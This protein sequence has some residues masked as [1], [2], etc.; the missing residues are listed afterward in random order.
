[1]RGLAKSTAPN[2]CSTSP[3]ISSTDNSSNST[4]STECDIDYKIQDPSRNTLCSIER[5]GSFS[6]SNLNNEINST[7]PSLDLL[8]SVDTPK[9]MLVDCRANNESQ[10][11]FENISPENSVSLSSNDL[12]NCINPKECNLNSSVSNEVVKPKSPLLESDGIDSYIVEKSLKN[13]DNV[14]ISL[15]LP[16]CLS[17]NLNDVCTQNS[18]LDKLPAFQIPC[19]GSK[20]TSDVR[21]SWTIRQSMAL[22]VIDNIETIIEENLL[23]KSEKQNHEINLGNESVDTEISDVSIE[24]GYQPICPNSSFDDS[25]RSCQLMEVE[26]KNINNVNEEVTVQANLGFVNKSLNNVEQNVQKK[27]KKKKVLDLEECSW[28]DLYDKDDD[29]IHPILMKEVSLNILDFIGYL[30]TM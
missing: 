21:K 15:D 17:D 13:C 8:L 26:E 5:K 3:N 30:K 6:Q 23:D 19:S 20:M 25:F 18:K 29:Y 28:E 22:H 10:N 9:K 24:T 4:L 7:L 1:M 11:S 14:S 12:S 27:K 16:M 2:T